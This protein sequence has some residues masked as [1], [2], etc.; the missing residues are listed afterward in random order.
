MPATPAV[1]RRDVIIV[2]TAGFAR[3]RCRCLWPYLW[4]CRG[5]LRDKKG[6]LLEG[7]RGFHAGETQGRLVSVSSTGPAPAPGERSARCQML[8]FHRCAHPRQHGKRKV[9][10][11][12]CCWCCCRPRVDPDLLIVT[13]SGQSRNM[14]LRTQA[15]G[16]SSDIGMS[17][18]CLDTGRT[19][20]T[21]E[22]CA[23]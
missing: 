18:S 17:L 13:D 21:R 1:I 19:K 23:A 16:E 12:L 11:W 8:T 15:W 14:R 6:R 20:S 7:R 2:R 3:S 22:P 5:L 9:A 10:A 4:P